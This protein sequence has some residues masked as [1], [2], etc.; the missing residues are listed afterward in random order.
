[1]LRRAAAIDITQFTAGTAGRH[2]NSSACESSL[3]ITYAQN[4]PRQSALSR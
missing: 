1:L 4:I 2:G 3:I